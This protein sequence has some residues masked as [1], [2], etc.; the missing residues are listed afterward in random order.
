M[1]DIVLNWDSLDIDSYYDFIL[2]SCAFIFIII[3]YDEPLDMPVVTLKVIGHQWYWSYEYSD[4]AGRNDLETISFDSYM[5]HQDDLEKGQLRLLETDTRVVLP[6]GATIRALVTS[7]MY[8]TV[9]Q[10][11]VWVVKWM[12]YLADWIKYYYILLDQDHFL[13]SVQ[14]Y[15]EFNMGLCQL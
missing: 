13:D 5:I 8:C 12:R 15:V 14:N 2:C 6:V 7:V 3:C 1:L 11:Q 9:G 10:F 4:Y